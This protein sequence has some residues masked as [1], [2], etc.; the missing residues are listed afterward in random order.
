LRGRRSACILWLKP[1]GKCPKTNA[2]T[3][4]TLGIIRAFYWCVLAQALGA[5]V[6]RARIAV[7]TVDQ[8][9][10]ANP[11]FTGVDSARIVIIAVD[12]AARASLVIDA[13]R[14][15]CVG[16]TI[17]AIIDF[18]AILIELITGTTVGV[19]PRAGGRIGAGVYRVGHAVTIGV[20]IGRLVDKISIFARVRLLVAHLAGRARVAA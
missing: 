2:F 20:L 7:A 6:F 14:G 15:R 3:F 4:D 11:C 18:V 16:T 12:L 9:V 10:N 19:N 13:F 8:R 1:H 5:V 17:A